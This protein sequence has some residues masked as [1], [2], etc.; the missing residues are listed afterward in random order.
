MSIRFEIH[1]KF[2]KRLSLLLFIW[3]FSFGIFPDY[4]YSFYNDKQLVDYIIENPDK[5]FLVKNIEI[6]TQYFYI[7]G[8][9]YAPNV[10]YYDRVSNDTLQQILQ[11]K[12]IYTDVIN[13]PEVF[14][15]TKIDAIGDEVFFF[16]SYRK[17]SIFSYK[18]LYGVSTVYKINGQ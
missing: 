12:P 3:N 14:D 16:D 5:T 6:G 4:Y 11:R 7:T 15:R 13:K 9:N 2:L 17:D 10:M 8:V 18:G 1:Q